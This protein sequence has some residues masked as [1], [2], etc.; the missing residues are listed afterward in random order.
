MVVEAEVAV[1]EVGVEYFLT[2]LVE[3]V[4]LLAPCSGST[5]AGT[6]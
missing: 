6:R 3:A 4:P 2:P 1:E 5:A